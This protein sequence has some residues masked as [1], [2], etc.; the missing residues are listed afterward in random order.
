MKDEIT[1]TIGYK[2]L[3]I[4]DDKLDQMAFRRL[5]KDQ[6]L[7]YD[8]SIAGSFAEAVKIL[9]SD[10]FDIVISDYSL[11]DGTAF[12]VLETTRDTPVVLATGAGDE[13]TAVRAMKAGACDYM[14]KDIERNYLKV[15]PHV[16]RN[17]VE[18]KRTEDELKQ[19]HSNLESLVKE[20][21]EQLAAEKE[22]LSVTLSSMGDAL[23]A[24]DVRKR[25]I[26]FNKVAESLTGWQAE[27]VQ[28][29][30][31]DEILR[32]IDE[33]T[34]KPIES[35]V[36]KVVESGQN[37]HGTDRD[38]IVAKNGTECPISVTATP[39]CK[40]NGT[41]I[42]IVIVLH[43]VSR[44][45][46]IDR[47]KTDFV[48]SVSHE[49]RTPLTSIKA[50]TATILRD[51][52]MPEETKR[53]FLTIIDQ[54]S[55][56]LKELIESVLELSRI[57]AGKVKL[58]REPQDIA[59]VIDQ[60]V[61]AL[62]PL[63]EKKN[64]QLKTDVAADMKP[65]ITDRSKLQSMLTNLVNNAIKF[66]GEKGS[67]SLGARCRD[68]QLLI[69][70]SDTGLGIPKEA[71]SKIFDRFYRVHRPGMQIQGTGLGL[72]IVKEI[73]MMHNGRI[74]VESQPDKGTT[75]TVSLPL[76]PQ[77]KTHSP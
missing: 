12:D 7:P 8:Y 32:I 19:Y 64:V 41:M 45:R 48:S 36:D 76:N 68:G 10:D 3:L 30:E 21:T 69:T 35:P 24:V 46:E 77:A 53:Q 74:E 55:D 14:I 43:D 57:E 22:L 40:N 39:L 17:A 18:H 60:V 62:R 16:I 50:Y 44:E 42:G 56:Q 27:K 70:V 23:I 26:L 28:G 65:L 20:R 13:E 59:V 67:V 37:G 4:E 25:I 51:P 5:V 52:N 6:A 61:S 31:I 58:V 63:A 72:A 2:I 47:M 66:T 34:K 38:A 54:E 33:K 71:L 75:F 1:E 11:G 73:V 9:D 15:L 49:L 29:E